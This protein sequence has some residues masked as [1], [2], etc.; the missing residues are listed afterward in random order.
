MYSL[1]G[2]IGGRHRNLQQQATSCIFALTL[3]LTRNE[4]IIGKKIA[5]Y[6]RIHCDDIFFISYKKK[7]RQKRV[8]VENLEK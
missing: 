3:R 5:I 7:A 6:I 1:A 4:A 8:N 2:K